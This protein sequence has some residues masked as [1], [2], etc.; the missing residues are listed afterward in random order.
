MKKLII[1]L[2]RKSLTTNILLSLSAACILISI[3]CYGL[4]YY[5]TVHILEKRL[6]EQTRSQ[7]ALNNQNM[8]KYFDTLDTIFVNLLDRLSKYDPA[9]PF[10]YAS[11]LN[12]LTDFRNVETIRFANY[13]IDTLDFYI[14][15]YPMLDSISIYTRSGTVISSTSTFT[16]TQIL[17]PEQGDFIMDS[18]I[19]AFDQS[20]FSFLWLGSYNPH[21]FAVGSSLHTL[22]KY[23]PSYVFTGIRR[24]A[25]IYNNQEDIFIVFNMRLEA[26]HDIYYTYPI[27]SDIGSVFL[28]NSDGEIQYSNHEELI[29]TRSPYADRLTEK[30]RFVPFTETRDGQKLNL[31]Y[32]SLND[33]GFFILYEIPAS[34]YSSDISSLRSISFL[35]FFVSMAMMLAI[36]FLLV[37]R[38][39]K[40]IK[41]LTRAVTYVG[42]GH[43]GYTIHIR[44]SNELGILARRFNKMSQDLQTIM[45]EKEQAEEQKRLHEIASLQSQINPHFILNTI[46]T[47]K[48][49]AILNHAPNISDCLTTFGKLLEP[50]LRQ[51]TDFYTLKEEFSYLKNYVEIMNYSY[52]NTIR[53][54]LS[55]PKEL[56]D[57]K[58]PRFILQPLVENAVLHG[59][60]KNTNAVLIHIV[61]VSRD[62][63]ICLTVS[64]SGTV[65][66]TDKLLE[67]QRSLITLSSPSPEKDRSIGLINVSQ[68][69]RLF[70]GESFDMWIENCSDCQ[71][72]VTV[73]IPLQCPS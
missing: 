55:C 16:K 57:C 28:L 65:I 58:I 10:S 60:D 11:R 72:K 22:D 8:K 1:Y 46:N 68:R 59:A 69:I 9:E 13:T 19:P 40:P 18:V 64:N 41:E 67:L 42:Q 39:L 62:A 47:V 21:A 49:M 52:G 44:E 17:Q 5:N 51:R 4:C 63:T 35:L 53:L 26:L 24:A 34:I 32:Q 73:I 12:Q 20:S 37:I 33:S 70:Y 3:L 61:V 66:L 2:K 30:N 31:F 48:W 14:A 50:L 15:N 36:V 45:A 38:K 29:G 43:F 27:T 25:N 71:V 23:D 54:E 7:V 6:T 56:L